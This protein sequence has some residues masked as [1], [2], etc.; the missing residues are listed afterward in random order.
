MDGIQ[1]AFLVLAAF[2]IGALFPLLIQLYSVLHT[3]RH[4]LEKTA[5]DIEAG[6]KTVHQVADR[7]DRMTADLEKGGKLQA[8]VAGVAAM[9][10]MVLQLRDTLKI[11]SAVGAAV[12]PAVGAAVRAWRSE[13]E[14][15]AGDS[16]PGPADP[17]PVRGGARE[18]A[19][20]SSR[21]EVAR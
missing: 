14:A 6:T 19:E 1:L 18:D 8:M 13:P 16:A 11:A 2:V 15:Q 7:V 9:S 3:L 5:K 20:E 17:A 4:V 10:D 21:K 12:V